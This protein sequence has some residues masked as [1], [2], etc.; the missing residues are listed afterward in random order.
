MN[1]KYA[2][3]ADELRAL[4]DKVDDPFLA[5]SLRERARHWSAMAAEIDVLERDPIYR[6]IHNRPNVEP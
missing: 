3:R 6:L 5:K 4:A 2:A 1:G